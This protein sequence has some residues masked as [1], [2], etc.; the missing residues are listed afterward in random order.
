M[1]GARCRLLLLAQPGP[2]TA[3]PSAPPHKLACLSLPGPQRQGLAY[4]STPSPPTF[5]GQSDAAWAG[6]RSLGEASEVGVPPQ[7]M[8]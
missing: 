4:C 3:N 6:P 1:L 8:V 5:N 7:G 2:L